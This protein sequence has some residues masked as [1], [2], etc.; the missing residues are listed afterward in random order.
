MKRLVLL[1]LGAIVV[2]STV[3][4]APTGGWAV[5]TV[6][7]IPDAW[8]AGKPLQLTWQ[9]RQ[10]G[11]SRL[12]GLHPTLEARAGSRRGTG[13]TGGFDE[14]GQRWHRGSMPI[15]EAGRTQV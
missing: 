15:A 3:A 12:D 6:M 5:V 4:F 7:K 10:H 1:G 13:R 11:A 8:I 9:V 2:A 14:G